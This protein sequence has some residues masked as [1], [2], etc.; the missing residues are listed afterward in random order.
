MDVKFVRV[1]EPIQQKPGSGAFILQLRAQPLQ[2]FPLIQV[3]Y[4]EDNGAHQ[5]QPSPIQPSLH[6]K[7][8]A[9][10]SFEPVTGC[11]S[12]FFFFP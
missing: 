3:A 6:A 4:L 9:A 2:F 7:S 8:H 10:R 1:H 11:G 12:L 5:G